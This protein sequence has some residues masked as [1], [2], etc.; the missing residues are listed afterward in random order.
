M[1]RKKLIIWLHRIGYITTAIVAAQLVGIGIIGLRLWNEDRQRLAY[2]LDKSRTHKGPLS[3]QKL[4]FR[5][6]A[7]D[8]LA[9]LPALQRNGLRMVARPALRDSWI[10]LSLS[11]SSNGNAQGHLK[12]FAQPDGQENNLPAQRSLDFSISNTE[13]ISLLSDIS[14]MTNDWDGERL[15]CLD[16]TGFAF[17]LSLDGEVT[18]GQGNSACSDNYGAVSQRVQKSINRFIP[19]EL[20]P[21]GGNWRPL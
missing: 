5:P 6:D 9:M 21:T 2:A 12:I 13:A 11:T 20:R 7:I 4:R 14:I 10:A 15:A 19:K 17:E 3:A 16:G 18:S 1:A 8:V